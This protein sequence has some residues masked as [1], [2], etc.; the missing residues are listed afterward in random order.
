MVTVISVLNNGDGTYT[1]TFSE[2]ITNLNP[3]TPTND[4]NVLLWSTGSQSWVVASFDAPE[5]GS[6]IVITAS[7]SLNDCTELIILD[8][9]T[10]LS[11]GNPFQ[12]VSPII[13]VL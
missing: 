3:G 7:G 11:A 6:T 4:N 1:I 8:Q 10:D 2:P 9:P 12:L 5:I 13:N